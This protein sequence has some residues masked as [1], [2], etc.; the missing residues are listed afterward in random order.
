MK[1]YRLSWGDGIVKEV[2]ASSRLEAIMALRKGEPMTCEI[3]DIS[4]KETVLIP[5]AQLAAG[6]TIDSPYIDGCAI[7]YSLQIKSNELFIVGHCIG[8]NE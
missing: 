7:R 1:L 6:G 8:S 3:V 2:M 5:L 4:D